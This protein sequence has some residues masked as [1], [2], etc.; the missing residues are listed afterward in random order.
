MRGA[1]GGEVEIML[2]QTVETRGAGQVAPLGTE[3]AQALAALGDLAIEFCQ[4]FFLLH[5]LVFDLEHRVADGEDQQQQDDRAKA[6]HA[7]SPQAGAAV[8]TAA[9]SR[10]ERARGLR[11]ISSARGVTRLRSMRRKLGARRAS[12]GRCR[13]VPGAAAL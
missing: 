13:L 9:R 7:A 3:N 8:R 6:N 12:R 10:A 5:H 2:R 1:D 11:A 4:G